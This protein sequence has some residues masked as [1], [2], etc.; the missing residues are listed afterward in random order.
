[1]MKMRGARIGDSGFKALLPGTVLLG[2]ITLL[3]FSCAGNTVDPGANARLYGSRALQLFTEGNLTGAVK[4]YRKAYMYAA[5][6][7]LPL[8]QAHYLFNIG[9]VWY[10][11]GEFD[12]AD[13][14]LQAAYREFTYYKDSANAG[15]AAG[16]IALVYCHS[17]N[18]DRAFAWYQ[19]GRPTELRKNSETAFWLTIQ[20]RI[21]LLQNRVPEASAWLDRAYESYK[22]E[23]SWNG[24]AQIDYYRA[25]IS[26]SQA[27]HEDTRALLASSLALLDKTPERYRRW[28]VLLASAT[29]C[30]CL[31]D[32]EA[33]ERFYRRSL[34]CVPKGVT[35]P[36]LDSV[37]TCPTKFPGRQ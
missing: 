36:P 4:E 20:A 34:D 15:T 14:A 17:G 31:K 1:M 37:Q 24:L 12:S 16:F 3:L 8:Q 18:Y 11:A 32:T 26:F 33:G 22:K 9:R 21:S 10:E 13:E 28:R 29:V 27:R 30:F 19:K 23:K 5:S 6:S 2:G 35:V 7:D 25:A